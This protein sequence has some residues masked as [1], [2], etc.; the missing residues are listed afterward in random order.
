MVETQTDNWAGPPASLGIARALWSLWM[1]SAL[2]F[3]N[4]IYS[5]WESKIC[6]CSAGHFS[7]CASLLHLSSP[8]TPSGHFP[9]FSHLPD[10]RSVAQAPSNGPNHTDIISQG[11][12]VTF[13][14]VL[15]FG[16]RHRVDGTVDNHSGNLACWR[17]SKN[18]W[19]LK[20][21][22]DCVYPFHFIDCLHNKHTGKNQTYN[23]CNEIAYYLHNWEL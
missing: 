2:H 20:D 19:N 23:K 15:L 16:Q 4:I 7:N 6:L 18:K 10:K 12:S 1:P 8:H 11:R 22:L 3:L 5:F 21:K 14:K 17:F 9:G 13:P